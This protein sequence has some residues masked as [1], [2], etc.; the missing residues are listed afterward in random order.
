MIFFF[1]PV[2]N[3]LFH[4][5]IVKCG[6]LTRQPFVR[7]GEWHWSH[8]SWHWASKKALRFPRTPFELV[9]SLWAMLGLM[10]L[11]ALFAAFNP[12]PLFLYCVL[13][14]LNVQ[15]LMLLTKTMF[16]DQATTD[17]GAV[18]WWLNERNKRINIMWF[19]HAVITDIANIGTYLRWSAMRIV[20]DGMPPH[21][22]IATERLDSSENYH[23]FV[24]LADFFSA[25]RGAQNN[26]H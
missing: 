5:F 11:L 1:Q 18:F 15:I 2:E 9:I 4:R 3:G 12:F 25:Q 24:E 26:D 19:R 21:L 22:D 17:H 8:D 6:V 14:A 16:A 13:A 23:V 10:S 20:V 7:C